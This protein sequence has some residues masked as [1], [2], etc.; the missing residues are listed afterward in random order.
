MVQLAGKDIQVGGVFPKVGDVAPA[1]TLVDRN[2]ED[3]TLS[4]PAFLVRFDVATRF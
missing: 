3:V 2:L 4:H 1:F